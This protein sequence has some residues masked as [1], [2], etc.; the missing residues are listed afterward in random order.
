MDILLL[1]DLNAKIV[2]EE[3]PPDIKGESLI[4]M[5]N[6]LNMNIWN[7]DPNAKGVWTR[8]PITSKRDE[9]KVFW[10]M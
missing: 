3:G 5:T 7:S 4:Q 10:T 9:K 8:I 1:G 6:S 2:T